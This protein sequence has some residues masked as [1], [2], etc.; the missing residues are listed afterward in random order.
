VASAKYQA[1]R[2][3]TGRAFRALVS[4]GQPRTA[5]K[6]RDLRRSTFSR[7]MILPDLAL[8][9]GGRA[10]EACIG[11]AAPSQPESQPGPRRGREPPSISG[12]QRTTTDNDTAGRP[13]CRLV[14][15]PPG[16]RSQRRG[17][18][19][20][21][22]AFAACPRGKR[23]AIAT[24]LVATSLS[25][26][27]PNVLPA[28]RPRSV[29]GPHGIGNRWSSTGTSGRVWHTSIAGQTAFTA[30]PQTPRRH[31]AGFEPSSNCRMPY[32]ALAG[33]AR[34]HRGRASSSG[35]A[36][37]CRRHAERSS[38]SAALPEVEAGLARNVTR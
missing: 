1:R 5:P 34:G 19:S 9:A 38:S 32:R 27:L 15:R 13:A 22:A 18:P 29:L 21:R 25:P 23:G 10:L 30:Q 7:V 17:H 31:G 4:K 11:L 14:A 36:G 12:Q 26:V 33:E 6:R 24:R 2:D 20:C 3:E 35:R 28:T 37:G 8:Q 16:P